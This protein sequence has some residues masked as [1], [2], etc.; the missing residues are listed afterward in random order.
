MTKSSFHDTLN[1]PAVATIVAMFEEYLDFLRK[2]NG[3][4]SA[5]WMSYVD[6]VGGIVLGLLRASREGDW[7]LHMTAIKH[8]IP[9]CFAY[10]KVN[11]ARYL[12]VYHGMMSNHETTHLDVFTYFME[13]G[14]SVQLGSQNPFGRI[15]VDQTTEEKFNKDTKTPGGVK[16]FSLKQ[17][18]VSRYS[19]NS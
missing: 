14:F 9:W 10:D 12:P 15:L 16:K 6:I 7:L 5:F 18:A 1:L 19:Q 3:P 11:Y 2:D 4:L 17:G 13:G 8:M